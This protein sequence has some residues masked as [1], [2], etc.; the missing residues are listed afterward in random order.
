MYTDTLST[1]CY[2][3]NTTM[4]DFLGH[5]HPLLVHLPIGFL[6]LAGVFHLLHRW[7]TLPLERA[8]SIALLLGGLSAGVAA[9]FGWWLAGTGTYDDGNLF[10]H[11]WLGVGTAVLALATWWLHRTRAKLTDAAVLGTVGLLTAAGHFGGNLTHGEGYLW[12]T[13]RAE[14]VAVLPQS[15]DSVVV[16]AHMIQPILEENCVRCHE[17]DNAKGGLLMHT[18]ADLFAGGRN[19]ETLLSGKPHRSELFRRVTLERPHQKAMPPGG[20]LPYHDLKLL[21]W[22]IKTG[23]DS[24]TTLAQLAPVDADIQQLIKDRYGLDLT[25]KPLVETLVAPAVAPEKIREIEARGWSVRPLSTGSP[26]LDVRAKST[27]AQPLDLQAIAANVTWLDLSKSKLRDLPLEAFVHLTQ[28]KLNQSNANDAMLNQL[29][30][31]PNLQVLNLYG[32]PVS[33]AILPKLTELPRL[34]RVYLSGTNIS[35]EAIAAFTQTNA[36]PELIREQLVWD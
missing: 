32:T 30:G 13:K 1:I 19:G 18:A 28:L 5:F 23:V 3:K 26:L 35:S 15:P 20:P 8:T 21:E 25:P 10:W 36:R 4:T 7:K 11:R 29:S 16:F 12:Q 14:T 9:L 22:W 24:T 2:P 34:E 33:E 31:L 17:P 6:L 27:D